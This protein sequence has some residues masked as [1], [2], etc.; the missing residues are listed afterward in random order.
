[1]TFQ[2]MIARNGLYEHEI[3]E[4]DAWQVRITRDMDRMM[5][6]YLEPIYPGPPWA[7]RPPGSDPSAQVAAATGVDVETVRKVLECVFREPE[8]ES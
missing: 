4:R 7:T 1:M 2:R 8:R 5:R 6:D 3:L